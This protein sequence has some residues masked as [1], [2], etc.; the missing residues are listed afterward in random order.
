M[1]AFSIDK[2]FHTPNS[3]VLSFGLLKHQA[4]RLNS[5]AWSLSPLFKPVVTASGLGGKV[6]LPVLT[7]TWEGR[8]RLCLRGSQEQGL[9]K[10]DGRKMKTT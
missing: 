1:G 3:D 4:R 7:Y 6:G 5:T 10:E 9:Q 2:L 8:V